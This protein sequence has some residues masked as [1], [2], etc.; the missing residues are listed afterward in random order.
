MK[1]VA[2][3]LDVDGERARLQCDAASASCPACASRGGCALQRL[4]GR[5]HSR[6]EVPA[7]AADGVR[8]APGLRVTVEVEEGEL[9]GAAARTYLPPLA[10]LLAGPL[11]AGAPAGGGELPVLLSALAGVLLGWAVARAW[12]RRSPPRIVVRPAGEAGHA[13]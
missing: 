2:R 9:L 3:V 10:G 13:T 4:A 11:L 8:L 1:A 12:L 6:L 7:H 5:R